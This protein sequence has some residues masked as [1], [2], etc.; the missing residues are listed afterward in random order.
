MQIY[1]CVCTY[2]CIYAWVCMGMHVYTGKYVTYAQIKK[3]W[4]YVY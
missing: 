1:I 3:K 4:C 2:M